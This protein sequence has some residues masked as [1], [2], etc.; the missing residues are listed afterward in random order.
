MIKIE[1]IFEIK[2]IYQNFRLIGAIY[3]DYMGD[4]CKCWKRNSWHLATLQ[5]TLIWSD[6][7]FTCMPKKMETRVR[8]GDYWILLTKPQLWMNHF[9]KSLFCCITIRREIHL[10][11][12]FLDTY[13]ISG[14]AWYYSFL[15]LPSIERNLW[16]TSFHDVE[17]W[18]FGRTRTQFK[19]TPRLLK[20]QN[21]MLLSYSIASF[22]KY[23]LFIWNRESQKEWRQFWLVSWFSC[24]QFPY[25]G[26]S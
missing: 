11:I 24:E 8:G 26:R 6:F 16:P 17:D 13:P 4:F 23:W 12:I 15:T 21:H 25:Y 10:H 1:L 19:S 5:L 2:I 14:K 20:N 3:S 9:V 22:Q 18:I 7:S